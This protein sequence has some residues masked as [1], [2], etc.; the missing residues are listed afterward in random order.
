MVLGDGRNR[1]LYGRRRRVASGPPL[2]GL[3]VL[4]NQRLDSLSE[5]PTSERVTNNLRHIMLYGGPVRNLLL[6]K[7]P[8]DLD[9]VIESAR[10]E[11]LFDCMYDFG[12]KLIERVLTPLEEEEKK[13]NDAFAR[14][15]TEPR[16]MALSSLA[17]S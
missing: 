5:S 3:Q 13:L 11:D 15:R 6:N 10:A 12:N 16:A 14:S 7:T 8:S 9:V 2:G 1:V 4:L 17:L